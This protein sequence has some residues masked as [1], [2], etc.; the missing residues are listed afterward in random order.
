MRGGI[1]FSNNIDVD[2]MLI[3]FADF[4]TA[5]VMLKTT[6]PFEKQLLLVPNQE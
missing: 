2:P 5:Q 6:A 1:C 3:L 4:P